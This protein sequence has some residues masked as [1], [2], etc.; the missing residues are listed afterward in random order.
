MK[1][2]AKLHPK[3]KA[4]FEHRKCYKI[5]TKQIGT[6][7]NLKMTVKMRAEK[8]AT[9]SHLTFFEKWRA[10]KSQNPFQKLRIQK[11]S[12]LLD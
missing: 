1:N 7:S 2:V 8:N 3:N 4:K 9:K 6:N 10:K 11:L 5:K 12:R